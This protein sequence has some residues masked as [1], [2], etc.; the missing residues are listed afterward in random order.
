MSP[1]PLA[2]LLIVDD[3]RAQVVAFCRTLNS[4]GYST[5]GA[6][7]GPAALRPCARLSSITPPP[8]MS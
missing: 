8:S 2:R 4:E 5:T 3:E 6:H 1:S 7:S